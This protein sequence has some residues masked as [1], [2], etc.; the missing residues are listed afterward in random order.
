MER[1]IIIGLLALAFAL[2]AFGANEPKVFST[3]LA[4]VISRLDREASFEAESAAHVAGLIQREYGTSGDELKWAVENDLSW[5]TI[6]AM[7]YIQATTGRN[8]AD[9]AAEARTDWESYVE[10]AGMNPSKMA[11]S[12]EKFLKL[13][14]TQRN[15]R[16]F[17]RLRAS[18]RV[19]SLPDL[20]SG[21]GLF[22]EAMDFRSINEPRPRKVHDGEAVL[23]KSGGVK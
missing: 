19:N 4:N 15:S 1:R 6:A 2:P 3:E 10:T 16:I 23:T 22:Q 12:L 11:R 20:G 13:A 18:R 14:E 7:A 8:F 9:F 21:F 5:G 17:A